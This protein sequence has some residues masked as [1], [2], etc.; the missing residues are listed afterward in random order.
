M[1]QTKLLTFILV[2]QVFA[3]FGRWID[4]SYVT[5]AYAQ[6]PDAGSQR[7]QVIEQQKLTND[8]LDRIID[9]TTTIQASVRD[10]EFT[11]ML[12]IALVVLVIF[13]FLR[14]VWAT[15]IPGVTVPL[16]DGPSALPR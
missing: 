5:P 1:K 11:L 10:V 15:I 2:L 12:T 3:F 4:W 6:V 13:L 8:K 14:N 16:V 7:L 9:R